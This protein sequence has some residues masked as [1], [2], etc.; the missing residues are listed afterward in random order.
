MPNSKMQTDTEP[1]EPQL[2]KKESQ[3]YY[4]ALAE[5]YLIELVVNGYLNSKCF[6]NSSIRLTET[7]EQA[8]STLLEH[9]SEYFLKRKSLKAF[10]LQHLFLR[11]HPGLSWL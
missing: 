3:A 11:T 4:E 7:G 8:K 1:P 2:H 9:L 6:L 5:K 10:Q